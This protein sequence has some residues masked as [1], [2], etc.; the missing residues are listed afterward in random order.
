[1]LR[2]LLEHNTGWYFAKSVENISREVFM[3]KINVLETSKVY[4]PTTTKELSPEQEAE[5]MAMIE[6]MEEDDDIEAVYHNIA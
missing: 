4:S 3:N 2:E 6:K 1:M 5:V